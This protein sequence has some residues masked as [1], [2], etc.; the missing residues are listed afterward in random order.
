MVLGNSLNGISLGL[1]RL[2]EG[3]EGQREWVETAL[4]LGA[5]RWE[6]CRG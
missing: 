5:S 2:M 4:A 6:A 3:L 1:D